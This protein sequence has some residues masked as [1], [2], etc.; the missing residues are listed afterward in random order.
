MD[1]LLSPPIAFLIYLPLIAGV[2][3]LG[4]RMAGP[5]RSTGIYSSGEEAP[6]NVATPGYK[7]FILI[8]F[9]F[10]ILHLGILVLASG[11]LSMNMALY[12]A[13][14]LLALIAMILK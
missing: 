6:Q 9:F 5:D 13:G 10:A 11:P 7:P 12:L 4:K 2:T 1:F 8:A 3:M 14:L